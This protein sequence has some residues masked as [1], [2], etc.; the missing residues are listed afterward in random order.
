M[1]YLER[2]Q[3]FQTMMGS[4]G[5]MDAFE[6]YYAE[7]CEVVEIPTG[8]T[9]IGKDAQRQAIIEWFGSVE[10]M[11]GGGVDAITSNE[12][13][14]TTMIESWF[15]VTFKGGNRMTMKEVGIQEWRGDQ[16]VRERFYY[17]LPK[18][19]GHA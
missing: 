14:A 12:D 2:A 6:K 1:T 8:E 9:R 17:D 19:N 5:S 15:D 13:Q 10:E 16:I 11:H 4:E 7:D 3:A 18:Q